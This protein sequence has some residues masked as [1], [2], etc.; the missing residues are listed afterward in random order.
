M[1]DSES[2]TISYVIV[3]RDTSLNARS[4]FCERFPNHR[5]GVNPRTHSPYSS[6]PCE[7]EEIS[8]FLGWIA[9]NLSNQYSSICIVINIG[10]PRTWSSFE[11]PEKILESIREYGTKLNVLFS[12]PAIN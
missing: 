8:E 3:V 12:S 6:V 10:T 7:I 5:G 11:V 4:L 1:A 2:D 9:Q